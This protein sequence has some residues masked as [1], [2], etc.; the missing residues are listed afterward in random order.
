MDAK[1]IAARLKFYFITDDQVAGFSP[2][3]QVR[4]A[5]DAGATVIQY[6]NKAFTLNDFDEVEAIGRLCRQTRP[7][8]PHRLVRIGQRPALFGRQLAQ[9]RPD[10]P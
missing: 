1:P 4:I 8:S 7:D 9:G 5:I 3:D 2:L 10:L 6:R